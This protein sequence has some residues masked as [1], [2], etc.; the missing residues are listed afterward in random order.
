MFVLVLSRNLF[1]VLTHTNGRKPPVR[2][3][4]TSSARH[5]LLAALWYLVAGGIGISRA[6]HPHPAQHEGGVF[7]C[8]DKLGRK[9]IGGF[10]SAIVDLECQQTV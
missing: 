1:A 9:V 6:I 3:V 10:L 7:R 5:R 4:A 8:F 2:C